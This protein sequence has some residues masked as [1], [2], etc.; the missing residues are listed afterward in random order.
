MTISRLLVAF[1]VL[2]ALSGTAALAQQ[3]EVPKG[4]FKTVHLL[5]LSGSDVGALQAVIADMNSAAA[6]AGHSDVRYRLYKVV[7]KQSGRYAYMLESS[8]PGGEVY[9][10]VHKTPEWVAISKQHPETE[11]LLKGEAYNRY[12]EVAPPNK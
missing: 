4:P 12:V 2:S 7:G 8:W 9:Q 11:A 5:N 10:S 3:E 6:K 1:A